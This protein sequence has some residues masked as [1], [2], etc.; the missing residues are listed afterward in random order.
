MDK[1][2]LDIVE[3]LAS[4]YELSLSIGNSFDL[5][6]NSD[7]FL[8]CLMQQQNLSYTGHF[9]LLDKGQATCI[10]TVPNSTVQSLK[11]SDTLFNDIET[12]KKGI[13]KNGTPAYH[14]FNQL[15]EEEYF[16]FCYFFVGNKTLIFL[17]RKNIGFSKTE[18]MRNSIIM[19]KFGLFIE[20]LESHHQIKQEIKIKNEQ[21]TTIEKNIQLLTEQNQELLKYI[22]SNNE[23]EKFAYRTSHDL[24]APLRTIIG[25]SN[26]LKKSLEDNINSDQQEYLDFIIRG[27]DQMNNL[28]DGILE[29]SKLNAKEIK[30]Q[31]FNLPEMLSITCT[32]LNQDL[33][34]EDCNIKI[35]HVPQT[36]VADK[37]KI[38]QLFL[39][40]LNNALK[41]T[42]KEKTP[43]II[44]DTDETKTDYVF[45][46]E[47]N[48]IGMKEEDTQ[49]IF[50]VFEKLNYEGNYSGSGIGL[51]TCKH[52]VIQH[53]GKIWAES[54]LGVGTTL[55]FTLKK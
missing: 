49:R 16:E 15:I 38:K 12:N 51:S 5:S 37:T 2:K 53:G 25:F 46:I 7:S 10:Q 6:E 8:K 11:F 42:N 28:I 47:D 55:F 26:I 33:S 36:I 29:Y 43:K 3:S 52:I 24:K 4:L 31:E 21:A 1:I 54:E 41:F 44:I 19:S 17:G 14:E 18:V 13:L 35:K 23:L 22:K 39:N 48:G 34:K 30:H 20:S 32:M 50:E 45:S 27:G 40:L 9:K